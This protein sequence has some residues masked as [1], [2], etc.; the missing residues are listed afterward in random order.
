MSFAARWFAQ[1]R[2]A[3]PAPMIA[4]F[5]FNDFIASLDQFYFWLTVKSFIVG[6]LKPAICIH[7]QS[8]L[9]LLIYGFQVFVPEKPKKRLEN[10]LFRWKRGGQIC[11]KTNPRI[12]TAKTQRPRRSRIQVRILCLPCLP[13]RCEGDQKSKEFLPQRRKD[14]EEAECKLDSLSFFSSL[15]N[16]ASLR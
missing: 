14:R 9:L 12:L 8:L 13:L 1:V 6:I 2:P 4:T 5:G 16:L 3:I 11:Q 10:V 7:S 15:A